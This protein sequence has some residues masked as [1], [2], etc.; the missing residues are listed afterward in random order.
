M[1]LS[2]NGKLSEDHES[3]HQILRSSWGNAPFPLAL[4]QVKIIGQLHYLVPEVG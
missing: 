1:G 2:H 4:T 3:L